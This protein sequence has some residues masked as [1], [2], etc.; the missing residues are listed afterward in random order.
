MYYRVYSPALPRDLLETLGR[1]INASEDRVYLST[2][3]SDVKL[4]YV[5]DE[6]LRCVKNHVDGKSLM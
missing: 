2:F 5:T 6:V 1:E 3:T 4:G